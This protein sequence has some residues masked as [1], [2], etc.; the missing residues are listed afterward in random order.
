MT[1]AHFVLRQ[2][3]QRVCASV[4]KDIGEIEQ[5]LVAESRYRRFYRS[6]AIED[7]S[8]HRFVAPDP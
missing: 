1:S 3:A 5:I 4:G 2:F 7:A 6:H 8:D